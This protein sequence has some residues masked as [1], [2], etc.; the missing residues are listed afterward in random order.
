MVEMV[1]KIKCEEGSVIK[2][3]NLEIVI[4]ANLC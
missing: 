3:L 4:N 1:A 2:A